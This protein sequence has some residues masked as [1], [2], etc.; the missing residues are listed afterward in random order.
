[1]FLTVAIG[2]EG[3]VE[4]PV[5]TKVAEET[6]LRRI[7]KNKAKELQTM[8]GSLCIEISFFMFCFR[9]IM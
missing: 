5:Y 8:R 9:N 6:R 7:N 4:E 2:I 1:M 3:D